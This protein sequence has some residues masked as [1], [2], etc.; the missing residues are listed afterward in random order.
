MLSGLYQPNLFVINGKAIAMGIFG[1]SVL[2][3][4][5]VSIIMFWHWQKY[6]LRKRGTFL[7]ELIFLVVAAMLTFVAFIFLNN[8]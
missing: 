4:A 6:S 8:L 7:L 1:L 3:V 2:F 5:V